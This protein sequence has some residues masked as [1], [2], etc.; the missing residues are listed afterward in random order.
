MDNIPMERGEMIMK[1]WDSAEKKALLRKFTEIHYEFL[2]N[3]MEEW[4]NYIP[5]KYRKTAIMHSKN[6]AIGQRYRYLLITVNPR[7][8]SNMSRFMTKVYKYLKK[9]WI[10]KS[11]T[12]IEWRNEDKGLHMHSKVWLMEGKK[13]YD[14]KRE[15]FNTFKEMLGNKLHVDILYSNIDGCFE[16]YIRGL[17]RGQPKSNYDHNVRLRKEHNIPDILENEME[18]VKVDDVIEDFKVEDQKLVIDDLEAE[19]V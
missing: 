11:M 1:L 19:C 2:H 18:N 17:K 6:R 13:P 12:C 16:K 15:V 4:I 8:G 3:D 7:E 5:K 14:C 10:K 9:K